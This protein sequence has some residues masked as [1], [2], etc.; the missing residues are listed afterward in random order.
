MEYPTRPAVHSV[1]ADFGSRWERMLF[2]AI[3][4]LREFTETPQFQ[5]VLA[6]MDALSFEERDLFVRRHLLVPGELER[7]GITPPEG[8]LI[9][10]SSFGDGRPT[11]FAVVKYLPNDYRKV[12]ITYDHREDVSWVTRPDLLVSEAV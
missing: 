9:Q 3:A 5:R 4:E 6:E 11:V 1:T 12:T 7:L 2:E 10:R 8:I